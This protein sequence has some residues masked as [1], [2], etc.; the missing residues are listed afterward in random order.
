MTDKNT[1]SCPRIL[2]NLKLPDIVECNEKRVHHDEF[3]V[4]NPNDIK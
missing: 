1:C 2:T 3:I 4:Y